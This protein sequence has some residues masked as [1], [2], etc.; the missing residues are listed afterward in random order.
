MRKLVLLLMSFLF[1]NGHYSH[2]YLYAGPLSVSVGGTATHLENADS[3]KFSFVSGVKLDYKY[4]DAALWVNQKFLEN[5]TYALAW[6]GNGFGLKGGNLSF[7]GYAGRLENPGLLQ[8][9][10]PLSAGTRTF[11]ALSAALPSGP[12]GTATNTFYGEGKVKSGIWTQDFSVLGDFQKRDYVAATTADF[13]LEKKQKFSVMAASKLKYTQGL[14][15]D[16]WY[17]KE[18]FYHEGWS[19]SALAAVKL[20]FGKSSVEINPLCY[21]S[22][23]GGAD[24]MFRGEVQLLSKGT[25]FFLE[26][27]VN[28]YGGVHLPDN[29]VLNEMVEVK[30]GINRSFV[31]GDGGLSLKAGLSSYYKNLFFEAGDE[32][33]A[34]AGLRLGFWKTSFTFTGKNQW[35]EKLKTTGYVDT[36]AIV[37]KELDVSF[38]NETDLGVV[39]GAVN[40]KYEH[41]WEKGGSS[42]EVNGSVTIN[43]SKHAVI[44][45]KGGFLIKEKGVQNVNGTV[46]VRLKNLF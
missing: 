35:E 37:A 22:P 43:A 26:S 39:V 42:G 1:L 9:L 46:S 18:V 16:S 15:S 31:F 38:E 17:E 11:S 45:C 36:L 44:S 2:D 30:S 12:S 27:F 25:A 19:F 14:K 3:R 10:Y 28:P 8:T 23:F 13:M 29:K 32:I 33:K 40:G 6:S 5:M 21:S 4:F 20:G 41:Q 34:G 7:S 24:F